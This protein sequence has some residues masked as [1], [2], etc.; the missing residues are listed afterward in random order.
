MISITFKGETK[1]TLITI[2][3][4]QVH[5]IKNKMQTETNESE[6]NSFKYFIPNHPPNQR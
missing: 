6:S 2:V 3:K 1:P 4:Y 5:D